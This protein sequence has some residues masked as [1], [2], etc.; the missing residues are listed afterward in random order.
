MVNESSSTH[1][2]FVFGAGLAFRAGDRLDL[3]PI[4]RI[5]MLAADS[6]SDPAS[7]IMA[8]FRIGIR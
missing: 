4:V 1:G 7:A 8:G 3:G 6:D 2:G 5:T